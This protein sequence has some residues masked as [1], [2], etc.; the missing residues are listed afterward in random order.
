MLANAFVFSNQR[1]RAPHPAQT[2]SCL[3]PAFVLT[4]GAVV[5]PSTFTQRR[6][7]LETA[8][9]AQRMNR[10]HA[11]TSHC[12]AW[13]PRR[14]SCGRAC[15]STA[16]FFAGSPRRLEH[17]PH[18]LRSFPLLSR[19]LSSTF[20][21]FPF[22]FASTSTHSSC[23]SPPP[24]RACTTT[25]RRPTSL[26]RVIAHLLDSRHEAHHFYPVLRYWNA[27][28]PVRLGPDGRPN[29]SMPR[30]GPGLRHLREIG[31]AH[32]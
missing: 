26:S 14:A 11:S 1:D 16:L 5:D 29:R 9:V 24:S 22:R 20:H 27:S 12:A 32:V 4:R 7:G 31:R 17:Q 19:L 30:L 15:P 3:D 10:L 13:A 21:L 2:P 6:P 25:V 18:P 23:R 8:F 28:I